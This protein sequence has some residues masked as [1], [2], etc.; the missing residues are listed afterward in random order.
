MSN[1]MNEIFVWANGTWCYKEDVADFDYMSDD[2]HKFDIDPSV[3]DDK[4][5]NFVLEMLNNGL[6]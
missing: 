1:L 6:L 3:S 2:Y 5:D 4:I